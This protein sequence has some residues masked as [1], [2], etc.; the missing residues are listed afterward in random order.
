MRLDSFEIQNNWNE[1]GDEDGE[2]DASYEGLPNSLLNPA[3][4][5]A[6]RTWAWTYVKVEDL[7]NVASIPSVSNSFNSRGDSSWIN[8]L[9]EG[10]HLDDD[11]LVEDCFAGLTEE[12]NIYWQNLRRACRRRRRWRG[13]RW[14]LDKR[15]DQGL[16]YMAKSDS[17]GG[18]SSGLATLGGT[19][20]NCTRPAEQ[21]TSNKRTKERLESVGEEVFRSF[22]RCRSFQVF[23][24]R[25]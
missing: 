12:E 22:R 24:I 7:V 8:E 15:L 11:C 6:P 16:A 1:R 20:N 10:R 5:T 17:N 18:I 9:I 2:D 3:D 25:S 4:L 19:V 21:K 13:C 14:R 23:L